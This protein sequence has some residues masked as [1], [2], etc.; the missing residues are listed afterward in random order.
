RATLQ[1]LVNFAR[2]CQQLYELGLNM[3]A[4]VVPEFK[5]F[6]GDRIR[7]SMEV[8]DVGVSPIGSV[9]EAQMAAFISNLFPRLEYMWACRS[10]QIP[11]A[12]EALERSWNR[13][14]DMI[15]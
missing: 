9:E 7:S 8:L 11:R 15:P 4:T 6:P 12:F 5:Q 13:V 1:C 14:G 3:D 2:H 10:G